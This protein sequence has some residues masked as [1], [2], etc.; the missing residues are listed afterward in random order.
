[1]AIRA[2]GFLGVTAY[3]LRTLP[4][5]EMGIWYV[6][7]NIA[8]FSMM[9][10]LGFALIIG[11]YA[12]Y[13]A[14]GASHP[15]RLGLFEIPADGEIN[16]KALAGLV[17]MAQRL[18][19]VFSLFVGVFMLL[20]WGGWLCLKSGQTGISWAHTLQF[21]LFAVGSALNMSG[22]FWPAILFGINHVRLYNQLQLLSLTIAYVFML[23]G[24]MAG[25]GI[26]ALVVGQLLI[27]LI[28]RALA[29]RRVLESIGPQDMQ[30]C[31][32]IPW[33]NLW[34]MTWRTGVLTLCS[35]VCVQG[36][37]LSC[38]FFTDLKTTASY[39]LM[40][41]M[42]LFLHSISA[43][44]VWVKHP[45]IAALRAQ[46]NNRKIVHLLKR[47]LPL[48]ML[49]YILGA[50]LLGAIAPILL[51][52]M[53]SNTQPLPP[54]QTIALLAF[55][56]MDLLLGHHSAILQIG[57]ETP[58][59]GAYVFSAGMTLALVWPLGSSFQVWGVIAAP[60]LSQIILN[61]WWTPMACWKRLQ[62]AA[63]AGINPSQTTEL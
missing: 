14:G 37:S 40:L 27:S 7:L 59:L 45:E 36:T 18:Y 2:L 34:P 12:S 41:Q 52:G 16:R 60:F 5:E 28:P 44:W 63:P 13:F 21:A 1:M 53:G 25:W 47:R 39:G 46:A 43:L 56:G 26:S 8:G 51:R 3:A 24:L 9:V 57:N 17:N 22:M 49:T 15:P 38:S 61:Y 48:S 11:R 10:D 30:A 58:H 4:A 23:A 19:L 54:L 32:P 20:A 62:I 42:A 33:Q 35:Y 31:T 50:V 6:M 55:I 29:R